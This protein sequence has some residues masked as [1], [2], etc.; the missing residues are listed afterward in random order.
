MLAFLIAF[1]VGLMLEHIVGDGFFGH[2]A[3]RAAVLAPLLIALAA[4][5][6]TAA[7]MREAFW[8]RFPSTWS[9]CIAW[10]ALT[11]CFAGLL[12][13]SGR[14]WIASVSRVLAHEERVVALT[15]LSVERYETRRTLC[16]RRLG[17]KYRTGEEHVCADKML[18]DGRLA[19]GDNILAI[20]A[21]SPL[22]FHLKALRLPS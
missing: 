8:S 19:P 1:F 3:W 20:G 6:T 15:A 10:P 9:R 21:A 22:G 17:F 7:P 2:Y 5:I 11:L 16:L 12:A 13:L 14:G 4:T 18:P